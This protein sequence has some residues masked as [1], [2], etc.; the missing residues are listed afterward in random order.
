MKF[1]LIALSRRYLA[2]LQ[3]HLLPGSKTGW[4]PALRLG[5]R[6]VALGLETLELARI[7]EQALSR[8]ELRP[9]RVVQTRRA[10]IFFAEAIAPIVETHRAAR[11]NKTELTRMTAMLKRRAAELA[12]AN[13]RLKQGVQ[14]RRS[15]EASLKRSGKHYAKLLKNSIRLQ[16][17]L[18]RRTRQILAAQEEERRTMSREL[19]DEIAQ[20][21][22]GINVRLLTLKRQAGGNAQRI[23]ND[24]ASTQ[25][26]VG[27]TTLSTRRVH[28]KMRK[29]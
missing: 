20:T 7:H 10:E 26:L 2:E 21:L 27:N 29:I 24:I 15:V 25:R 28:R 19:Q 22:L 17:D 3:K 1:K 6:A 23:R 9:D 12:A 16:E 5:R 14:K 18:R 8:L 4:R 11:E 13:H